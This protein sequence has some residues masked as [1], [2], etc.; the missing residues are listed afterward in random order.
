MSYLVH[1][2]GVHRVYT[3]V[4]AEFEQ[5]YHDTDKKE[6]VKLIGDLKDEKSDSK[7]RKILGV[8]LTRGAEL[9]QIG[10]LTAQLLTLLH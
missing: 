5:N 3:G 9:A 4:E 10:S 8:I 1:L 6:L 2:P 7:K